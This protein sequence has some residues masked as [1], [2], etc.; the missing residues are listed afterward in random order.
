MDEQQQATAATR[1]FVRPIASPL[2][3]GF[4]G[5]AAGT[6]T[7]AGTELSW[8]SV[9]Q[10]PAAGL[11]IL[12]FV[13]PLQVVSFIFGF[14]ARDSAAATGMGLQA[15]GWLAIGLSLFTSPPTATSGAL[16]L[17][18]IGAAAGLLIPALTATQSK[19]LAGVVM[20]LTA[21]RFSLTAA[22][23]LSAVSAWKTAAGIMGLVL[24]AVALYAG[25]AFEV[26][27]SRKATWAPTL[28]R[29]QGRKAIAG[30]LA[31]EVS[32]VQNEAGVRSKL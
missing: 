2:A 21:V 20:A 32:Q 3:L 23:Q 18:L 11:M 31:D 30:N 28:R 6:F 5:L 26:E 13:V 4:L 14:L 24:M 10:R 8:I 22:Y 16:G 17:I 27:D 25:L 15:G 12:G 19:V 9:T 7:V 29:G 1:V